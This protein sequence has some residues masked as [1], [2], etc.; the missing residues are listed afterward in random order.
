[1]PNT[2]SSVIHH[3]AHRRAAAQVHGG[4]E[5]GGDPGVERAVVAQH[6]AAR[7]GARAQPRAEEVGARAEGV[8]QAAPVVFG[9]QVAVGDV[10]EVEHAAAVGLLERAHEVQ[11]AAGAR[12]D[13]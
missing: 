10:V 13:G 3:P 5:V 7:V 8:A 9:A 1:M 11:V 6:V 12:T 4:G 2:R